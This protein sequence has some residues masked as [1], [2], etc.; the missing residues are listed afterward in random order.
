VENIRTIERLRAYLKERLEANDFVGDS[1]EDVKH[2]DETRHM[3]DDARDL[4]PVL[5][6]VQEGRE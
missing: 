5:R 3:S 6:A 1:D 2:E 4:Y